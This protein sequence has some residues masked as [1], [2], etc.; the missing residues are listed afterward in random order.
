MTFLRL[1][2]N[3][4]QAGYDY[5]FDNIRTQDGSI[6]RSLL[7]NIKLTTYRFDI[8]TLPLRPTFIKY[9]GDSFYITIKDAQQKV[10]LSNAKGHD[11]QTNFSSMADYVEPTQYNYEMT[12]NKVV[13]NKIWTMESIPTTTEN[14][15]FLAYGHYGEFYTKDVALWNKDILQ[16]SLSDSEIIQK[17]A[18]GLYFS[19]V[20]IDWRVITPAPPQLNVVQTMID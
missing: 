1:G 4:Q 3:Q 16:I 11:E 17:L 7:E 13:V 6:L 10:F 19:D 20:L 9:T 14:L 18:D 8:V 12:L 5:P 2:I 15:P